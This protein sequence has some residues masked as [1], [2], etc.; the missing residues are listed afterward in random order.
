[1]TTAI[2]AT[3]GTTVT[4]KTASNKALLV[5][6]VQENLLSPASRLHVDPDAVPFF[7]TQLNKTIK[8]FK[9]DKA[10]VLYV[11]NE[12][13]N[14]LLNFLTGN[15]C[16]KGGNGTGIDKRVDLVSGT[17]YSKS[18]M[19]ALSNKG[20]LQYLH[21]NSI[22]ELYIT[23]LFAEACVRGTAKGAIKKGYK[24]IIIEDA[25]GSKNS[26]KKFRAMNV[27]KDRGVKVIRANQLEPI[28][29]IL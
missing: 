6:D 14:P 13:T 19:N 7:I 4:K 17:I 1:M 12:W 20:L 2:A 3:G 25:V 9:D 11:V 23:G 8:Y 21:Q 24:T 26:L 5:I 29:H 15:V 18:K 27:C 16:K 10:H 28:D 22:T